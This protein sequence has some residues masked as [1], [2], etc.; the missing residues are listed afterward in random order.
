MDERDRR[1]REI[2]DDIRSVLLEDW[3][4]IGFPVPPDEYDAYIGRVYR[5]LAGGASEAEVARYL[6]ALE[7]RR[8]GVEVSRE[9]L[10][11]VAARLCAIDVRL[12]RAP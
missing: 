4:P 6:E 1:A 8:V 5:L 12:E 2:Q 10:S 9:T 11:E 3:N 7:L